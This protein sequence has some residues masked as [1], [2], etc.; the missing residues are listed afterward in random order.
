MEVSRT[1][2]NVKILPIPFPQKL[3]KAKNDAEFEKFMNIFKNLHINIPFVDTIMQIPSYARFLKEFMSSKRKLL[4][5]KIVVLT[6]E[7]NARI[8]NKLPPK[9]QDP[10]SFS[11]KN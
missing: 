10:G 3:Q 7:S 6:E 5:N 11:K 9:L 1:S 2:D 4:D 8:Q